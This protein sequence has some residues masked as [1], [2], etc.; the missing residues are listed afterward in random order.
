[1][2]RAA[3]LRQ[4]VEDLEEVQGGKVARAALLGGVAWMGGAA[5][6]AIMAHE[7]GHY[8]AVH[9]VYQN[10]QARIEIRPFV[11]GATYY[12]PGPLTSFGERLG[13]RLSTALVAGAG[14][15]VDTAL[16]VGTFAAGYR[17]RH[18]HPLIGATLMGFAGWTMANSVGYALSALGPAGPGNDFA[19]LAAS[20][21]LHPLV[22][23]GLLASILPAEYLLLRWAEKQGL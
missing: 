6:P 13:P 4:A 5:G 2:S 22:T 14:T 12:R 19:A 20:L 17:M 11:G 8:A 18:K 15:L 7:L 9:A 21:G 3:E 10:P 16:S 1:L 23:A